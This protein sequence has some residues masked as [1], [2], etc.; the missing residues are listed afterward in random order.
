VITSIPYYKDNISY[1]K[2]YEALAYIKAGRTKDFL[3]LLV[4]VWGDWLRQGYTRFPENFSVNSDVSKQ[5]EFYDRSF[6]LSLC[7]GANG[8]PPVVLA[9][10]GIFGFS[11]SDVRINEY[12]LTPNLLHLDWAKGRIPVK[13]GFIYIKL[14][15][16]GQNEVEI[17]EGCQVTVN[18][19]EKAQVLRKA[20]KYTF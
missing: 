5:L 8:V 17:P 19:G 20:G 4:E 16:S 7:H 2:G 14:D 18:F 10:Y 1:E 15:K 6:G 11:Q 13:E 12:T 9:A 3:Q